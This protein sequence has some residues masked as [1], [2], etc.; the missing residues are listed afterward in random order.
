MRH[1]WRSPFFLGSRRGT[2]P[3]LIWAGH[4]FLCYATAALACDQGWALHTWEG[5]SWLQWGLLA[6]S[7]VAVASL[8]WLTGA[9]CR[10]ALLIP[11]STLA[12]VRLLVAFLSLVATVW[13]AVP[14]LWLPACRFN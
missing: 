7:V 8:A 13:T 3:L 6:F 9:A 11:G 5:I 4:F 2:V 10:S 14:I 12:Q 1:G